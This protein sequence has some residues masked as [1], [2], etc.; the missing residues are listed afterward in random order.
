[1]HAVEASPLD[2]DGK[3]GCFVDPDRLRLQ[4]CLNPQL[5][6]GG[7]E[8]RDKDEKDGKDNKRL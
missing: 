1:M 8:G 3:G 7:G 2:L 5:A 6:G 4:G